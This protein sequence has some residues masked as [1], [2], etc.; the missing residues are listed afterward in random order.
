MKSLIKLTLLLFILSAY[1]LA[2]AQ[3][4]I[5]NE[6]FTYK[7][8]P[9]GSGADI[10]YLGKGHSFSLHLSGKLIKEQSPAGKANN[11]WLFVV[12]KNIIQTSLVPLPQPIPA[13]MHLG[14]LTKDETQEM[15]N[16]YVGY[17][18]D[19]FD[20]ELKLNPHNLYEKW[21]TVNSKLFLVWIFEFK[22]P[23]TDTLKDITRQAYFST[24]CFNQVLDINMPLTRNDDL[25]KTLDLLEKLAFT[26]KTYDRR[27][28]I[29]E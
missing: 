25:G 18:M 21:D 3:Q 24:V 14:K 16:G 11:Q 27:L 7:F 29:K 4:N 22:A 9:G 19:Y 8:S 2:H 20:K 6:S 5:N 26:L 1:S 23:N 15:L 28:E 12:D 17:E 13:K 10:F